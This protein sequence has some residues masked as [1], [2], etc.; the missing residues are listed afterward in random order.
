M[1]DNTPYIPTLGEMAVLVGCAFSK[2]HPKTQRFQEVD[3]SQWERLYFKDSSVLSPLQAG[4]YKKGDAIVVTFKGTILYGT[5][6]LGDLVADAGILTNSYLTQIEDAQAIIRKAVEIAKTQNCKIYIGGH[7]LGGAITEGV[8]SPLIDGERYVFPYVAFNTPGIQTNPSNPSEQNNHGV[9]F[10]MEND[11]IGHF[12]ETLSSRFDVKP[13]R[14]EY[15][16]HQL[17]NLFRTMVAKDLS[18]IPLTEAIKTAKQLQTRVELEGADLE[19]YHIETNIDDKPVISGKHLA[20]QLA[21]ERHLVA[22]VDPKKIDVE[23]IVE[24]LLGEHKFPKDS[25]LDLKY[26]Y[27][28]KAGKNQASKWSSISIIYENGNVSVKQIDDAPQQA[29]QEK[30]FCNAVH[31]KT[32][33]RAKLPKNDKEKV[34]FSQAQAQMELL[35]KQYELHKQNLKPNESSALEKYIESLEELE[36]E[37][38]DL[39]RPSRRGAALEIQAYNL[40]KT[41]KTLD[42]DQPV[43]KKQAAIQNLR[44][45][46]RHYRQSLGEKIFTR[47][48]EYT[49]LVISTLIP[50]VKTWLYSTFDKK[51]RFEG[52]IKE[53][54]QE[55]PLINNPQK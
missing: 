28:L 16:G 43:E 55:F 21:L 2:K 1:P 40:R 5:S 49:A 25:K 26:S 52:M 19:D 14:P 30:A 32:K 47:M 53:K 39:K 54:E 38:R 15:G 35:R 34:A 41:L 6:F 20:L 11:I 3:T 23:F 33:T 45:T 51:N 29:N 44:E 48:L 4:I 7:S 22:S 8:S 9:V 24:K 13:S 37:I 36:N 27:K 46:S 42:S 31:I 18:G 10:S 50:P 12:G 17:I